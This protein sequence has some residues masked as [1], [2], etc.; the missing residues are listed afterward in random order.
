[1]RGPYTRSSDLYEVHAEIE[2]TM[3]DVDGVVLGVMGAVS[4]FSRPELPGAQADRRDLLSTYF[5]ISHHVGGYLELR[6]R[7]SGVDCASASARPPLEAGGLDREPV[8]EL[9]H[10]VAGVSLHPAQL[11]LDRKSTRL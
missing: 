2:G 7:V 11:D 10:G 5:Y 9:V 8:D 4:P 6:T 1:M 3:D